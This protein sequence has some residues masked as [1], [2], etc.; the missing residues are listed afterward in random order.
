[1]A[2]GKRNGERQDALWVS[3]DRLRSPGHPF[4]EALNRL[5]ASIEFDRRVEEL[6]AP[7]YRQGGRPGIPPGVYY[8]MLFVGYF[9]G[10]SSQR[11]IEWR[12]ADSLCCGA[13]WGFRRP[14][15]CRT[16]RR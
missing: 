3:A 2:L 11:A 12:C 13:T 10:L 8:R 15:A 14:T 9:E 16:T 1:M 5:L 7:Y 6:C 4:Y